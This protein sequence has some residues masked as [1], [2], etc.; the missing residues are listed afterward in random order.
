MIKSVPEYTVEGL[1]ALSPTATDGAI[2][3]WLVQ[4][5]DMV[6]EGSG[7]AE[8]QTDKS[9]VTWTATDEAYIAKLLHPVA[10]DTKLAVGTPLAVLVESKDDIPA[11]ANVD[12]SVFDGSQPQSPTQQVWFYYLCLF[13]Y[14]HHK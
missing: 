1:P 3:E 6:E 11:F 4:V 2:V 8:I 5:G 7:I 10:P 13:V 9:V 14:L 12:N